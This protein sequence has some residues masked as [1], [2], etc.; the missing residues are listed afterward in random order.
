MQYTHKNTWGAE[1]RPTPVLCPRAS[2]PSARPPA[3]LFLEA[4]TTTRVLGRRRPHDRAHRKEG[5]RSS[6]TCLDI[7][8]VG[9]EGGGAA[10]DV[11]QGRHVRHAQRPLHVLRHGHGR[12]AGL[13]YE[14][15]LAGCEHDGSSP[16][17]SDETRPETRAGTRFNPSRSHLVPWPSARDNDRLATGVRK[18]Q[19]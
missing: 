16:H 13:C 15:R 10:Q 2:F 9:H 11:P 17:N 8:H 12:G 3:P 19:A 6:H 7:P 18:P 1:V 4:P 5:P 14:R